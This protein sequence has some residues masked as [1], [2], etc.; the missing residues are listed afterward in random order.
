MHRELPEELLMKNVP[1]ARIAMS[2]SPARPRE[3]TLA[4]K[5]ISA[6]PQK[7]KSHSMAMKRNWQHTAQQAWRREV[8]NLRKAP[9]EHSDMPSD[10]R[11]GQ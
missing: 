8:F 11:Y 2:S 10:L 4:G 6:V 1:Q 9:K 7:G 5:C 3:Y